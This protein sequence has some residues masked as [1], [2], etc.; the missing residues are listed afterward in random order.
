MTKRIEE[1]TTRVFDNLTE[2]T[3]TRDEM[4]LCLTNQG[5]GP[6]SRMA[7]A[8]L[9]SD[10]LVRGD[11]IAQLSTQGLP[12][13]VTLYQGVSSQRAQWRWLGAF[14]DAESLHAA[15]APK[16]IRGEEARPDHRSTGR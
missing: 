15:I 12:G 1:A 5:F 8:R 7:G 4:R 14:T 11:M 6:S 13:R 10:Y 2:A 3:V 9:S 16:A